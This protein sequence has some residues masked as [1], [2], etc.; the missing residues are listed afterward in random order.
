M[1][2]VLNYDPVAAANPSFVADAQAAVAILNARFTN[3]ITLTFDIGLGTI[4][5][6]DVPSQSYIR[7]PTPSPNTSV[8]NI[9]FFKEIDLTYS[10]L[11][12]NLLRFGQPNFFTTTNLPAGNSINNISNFFI[13]SSVGKAFGLP[14]PNPPINQR[15]DLDGYIGIGTGFASG[16]QR[17]A[18][19]LHEIG[20]AMGRISANI[21]PIGP[22]TY[23]SELD[24]V[25][26]TSLGNR[27]FDGRNPN[28]TD[29]KTFL[30]AAYFSL[31][32]GASREADWG[33]SSDP[34]DFLNP[35]NSNR[36]PNDPFNEIVGT[37]GLLTDADIL[38]TE[39]LG[40]RST[41]AVRRPPPPAGT[42]AV[43]VLR[44]TSVPPSITDGTYQIYDIGNNKILAN[45]QLGQ[46]GADW[47]FVTLGGFNDGDT[48][49]MLLRNPASGAFQ[50]YDIVNN[51]ITG[52]ASLG[53]VGLNF[54][55]LGFG[56]FGSFGNTDMM[57]RDD[58]TG[59]LQVYNISNNQ[60]TGSAFMG[61]VGLDWQF[62][63]VGNFSSRGTSDMLLRNKDTGGLQVYDI[64]S[65]QITGSF[66]IGNVGLDW[67]FSG[68]GNFSSVPG[69]SD[70]LLRNS[71]TGAL[72][73]YNIANNQL[74]G[75]ASL[76][77]V[78]LDWQFAGVA[79]VSAAGRSDLV[80]RN[81]NTGA[82]QAY[83]IAF[84]SLA[85]SASLGAVGL[86]WQLGGLAAGP[87]S[88]ST[89][90]MDD[91]SQAAQ[92][93]QAMAG[94]GGGT[95]DTSNTIDRNAVGFPVDPPSFSS[96]MLNPAPPAATTA[97]MVLRNAPNI[98]AT[99][100]IYNLGANR[101]LAA[102]SL[103]QVGSEWGFV[104][105][106]NFNSI[107][108]S[109]MLLRNS[110]SGA[111]QVYNIVNNNI[112]SSTS[113]GTVGVEWQPMGF[114]IFFPFGGVGETDML[115]R[116]VNTGDVQVY[117]I[118][119]NEIVDSAFLG[120]IGLEWQFSG[121]GN[122]GSNGTSDL[123]VRDSDPASPTAGELQVYNIIDAQIYDSAIIGT[124]GLEWQ[125][126]G[127]GDFSSVPG[128][129]DLLL[130]NSN[131][132]AL[133]IYDI[134]DNQLTGSAFIGT[135]GLEWQFAG[136]A[137]VRG[138]SGSDL[139]LRNVNTGAFQVYNIVDHQL[140]GSA[141]LGAVG[142]DWQL[143]G[144]APT[145][146]LPPPVGPNP[147]V[148]AMDVSTAQLVQAMASFGG[149]GAGESLNAAPLSAETSQ[150]PLLTTPHA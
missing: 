22:V 3:N 112:I 69:E 124:V 116:D 47:Q 1:N 24:L 38:V 82:F 5:K 101:V 139:V 76:G 107:D 54:K 60:I 37:S 81:V 59:G 20:H 8:A 108:P 97:D 90:S 140:T 32:G 43:M 130:R 144:F 143:G 125:F 148:A 142:V 111:F 138:S 92:L 31:D 117:D 127:V 118:F 10:E 73:V 46:V 121:I 150:Q 71:N 113:L 53:A 99:Y 103:G 147:E 6:W 30:P 87:P 98:T 19:I 126:S 13:S 75:S 42:I 145:F 84:N 64:N 100:E 62:S 133:Q 25:R 45:Y 146:S 94:L 49:D 51:N 149:S 135:V 88:G 114:G 136:V 11:R 48:S 50:I 39:A 56:N 141:P 122:W 58:N 29:P 26:F 34:S 28:P 137:P 36:T 65:N 78:G 44:Q 115:L 18:A 89:A 70:L 128:E 91:P 12:T 41:L 16:P 83:N 23:Y 35:P 68:V 72:Q 74:T 15:P 106:G 123:L 120:T 55:V 21:G 33:V 40:F 93:A 57:L 63:G 95:A 129:S 80:L 86:D 17:V 102:N 52:S 134:N 96:L 66:F 4:L 61:L 119:D 104:T 77:A 105:L 109:D 110:S 9:N 85:G 14:I 67:Q 132:G 7:G 131:T 2:I 79:P 27:L